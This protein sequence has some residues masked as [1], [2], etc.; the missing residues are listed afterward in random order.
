MFSYIMKSAI[1]NML[2][3]KKMVIKTKNTVSIYVGSSKKIA[4]NNKNNNSTYT[5]KSCKPKIARVDKT[6]GKIIA[7]RKGTTKI[8][9]IETCKETKKK[10]IVGLIKV[11]VKPIVIKDKDLRNNCTLTCRRRWLIF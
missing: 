7:L 2:A 4:L 5:F 11:I 3:A 6:S 8:I 10:S 1:D 9:I